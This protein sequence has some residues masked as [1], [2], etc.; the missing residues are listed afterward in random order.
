LLLSHGPRVLLVGTFHVI[1][2]AAIFCDWEE[3]NHLKRSL[4]AAVPGL[5]ESNE[6]TNLED[7]RH[8]R[9]PSVFS[10]VGVARGF[11]NKTDD[12]S[13]LGLSMSG[14]ILS[15]PA[16]PKSK[17]PDLSGQRSMISPWAPNTV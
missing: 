2:N 7:V 9:I 1:L 14:E 4:D 17:R 5:F 13:N 8:V 6:F 12:Q 16:V 15:G 3:A 10:R 11:N